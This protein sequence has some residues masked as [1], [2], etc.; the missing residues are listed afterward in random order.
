[1]PYLCRMQFK[2][3]AKLNLGLFVKEKRADGFHEI[4]SL[5]LPLDWC[6]LISF[7]EA[8]TL[9]FQSSGIEIPQDPNGNLIIQAYELLKTNFD[10]PPLKIH[11]DKQ[12]PIGAGLGGGSSDAAHMLKA[13]N[14]HFQ[15]GLSRPEL[16]GIAAEL[17]SDCAFFIEN[18]PAIASGRGEILDQNI[19]LSL[20]CFVLMIVPPIHISTK[21][22]YANIKL[23]YER[24]SIR[25]V[26][27]K[28]VNQWKDNLVNDFEASIFPQ[29]PQLQDLKKSLYDS[30]A[31]YASMS[32]SGSSIFGL[33]EKKAE[34]IQL[35]ENHSYHISSID[36]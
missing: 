34:H 3:N 5:F 17:G 22:A 12:I 6:D 36:F 27:N 18:K 9:S 15:L 25:E 14:N 23:K 16:E 4:E 30:G 10:L 32:G 11:L 21:D 29:H 13:L 31:F 20:K 24:P 35:P 2:A 8:N 19:E 28:P 1:M 33:F 26:L 7:E